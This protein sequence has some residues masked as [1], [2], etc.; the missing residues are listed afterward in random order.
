MCCNDSREL[1]RLYPTRMQHMQ[2]KETYNCLSSQINYHG[3][4]MKYS[5]WLK[6]QSD[7]KAA[8][9]YVN[10]YSAVQSAWYRKKQFEFIDE[11]EAVSLCLQYLQKNVKK[12]E[13]D[14]NRYTASYIYTVC[15]NCMSIL[16]WRKCDRL[17]YNTECSTVIMK[18][19]KEVDVLSVIADNRVEE[20]NKP[21]FEY[22]C[23]EFVEF[24]SVHMGIKYEKLIYS[25][26]NNTT[27]RRTSKSNINYANNPLSNVSVR[28]EE[29][30]H[31]MKVLK[32]VATY[33]IV[34]YRPDLLCYLQ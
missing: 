21:E 32:V 3:T 31:M 20:Y 34:R 15:V 22:Q 29:I 2:F 19:D 4:N 17:R 9:L 12:I 10:F 6:K 14:K 1:T 27:T 11:S 16:H 25:L 8:F 30:P 5:T 23:K 28:K 24:V 33:Y 7:L 18:G 13:N 26:I